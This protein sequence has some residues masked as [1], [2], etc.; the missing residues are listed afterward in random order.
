[1]GI[2]TI[3]DGLTYFNILEGNKKDIIS[4][5][6][7]KDFYMHS[8][9]HWLGLDVHDVGDYRNEK[10][11]YPLKENMYLTIEPGIYIHRKNENV[12]EK[13]R[14]IGIRI[15]DDILITKNGNEILSQ[16]V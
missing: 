13:W 9:G 11:W 4:N 6:L 1:M 3:S 16:L 2:D 15:E 12:K 7:Y 5:E 10:E 8:A 14:G